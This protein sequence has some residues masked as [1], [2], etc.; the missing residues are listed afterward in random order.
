MAEHVARK[1]KRR[2]VYRVLAGKPEGKRALG[3]PRLGG[4][5]ILRCIFRKWVWGHGLD[6]TGSG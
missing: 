2:G 1:G 5:I 4:R 3:K 6:R